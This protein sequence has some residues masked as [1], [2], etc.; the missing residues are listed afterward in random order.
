MIDNQVEKRTKAT[1]SYLLSSLILMHVAILKKPRVRHSHSHPHTH[2][3]MSYLPPVRSSSPPVDTA[4]P[5][6]RRSF[7]CRWWNVMR[8]IVKALTSYI[9]ASQVLIALRKC[10]P[11]CFF[12]FFCSDILAVRRSL[13]SAVELHCYLNRRMI[14]VW[15]SLSAKGWKVSP[16]KYWVG[17]VVIQP[18]SGRL[19]ELPQ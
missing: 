17:S 12:V 11:F 9:I 6:E 7:N 3:R 2:K 19:R 10:R 4:D 15:A 5:R 18:V 8:H 16:C 14:I 13:F 1:Q